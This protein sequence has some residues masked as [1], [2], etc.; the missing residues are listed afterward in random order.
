[1]ADL[2]D[3]ALGKAAERGEA[4]VQSGPR[5]VAVRYDAMNGRIVLELSNGCGYAFP[6]IKVEDLQGASPS[7]LEQ[8]EVDGM[9]FN[10]HWPTLD[11]DLFVPSLVS[12]IFGTKKWMAQE[13]A[14]MAGKVSSP[15]KSAAAR[16]NGTKGGRPKK[17]A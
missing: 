16:I 8:V 12:G 17:S 14:R 15:A 1:M 3:E 6:S 11:V 4:L 5:A 9:G 7:D 13:L 10:L 2:T